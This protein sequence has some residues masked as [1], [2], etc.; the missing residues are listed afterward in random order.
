MHIYTII[1]VFIHI[2]FTLVVI[3][4]KV[5]RNTKSSVPLHDGY[6]GTELFIDS[7]FYS[8]DKLIEANFGYYLFSDSNQILF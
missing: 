7:R 6:N 2:L 4:L 8:D 3:R 1:N 5:S